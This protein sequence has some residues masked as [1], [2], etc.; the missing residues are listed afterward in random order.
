[1]KNPIENLTLEELIELQHNR[2]NSFC[3]AKANEKGEI[4]TI[5]DNTK[6]FDV[7]QEFLSYLVENKITINQNGVMNLNYGEIADLLIHYEIIHRKEKKQAHQ[8][9][10]D[11]AR[12]KIYQSLLDSKHPANLTKRGGDY[13]IGLA[14]A[15]DI[16]ENLKEMEK[17]KAFKIFEAGQNS[18]EEGGKSFDQF[19][20]EIYG[21]KNEPTI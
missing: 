6:H 13:R 11:I 12:E 2:A 1:M 3:I 17:Q 14:K 10:L 5:V 8:T 19:W 20:N 16:I 9:I 7:F 15:M 4:K 18:M 21:G